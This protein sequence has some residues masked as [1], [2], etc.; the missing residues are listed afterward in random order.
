MENYKTVQLNIDIE[1]MELGSFAMGINNP[2]SIEAKVQGL[3]L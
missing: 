2:S 1:N 3:L